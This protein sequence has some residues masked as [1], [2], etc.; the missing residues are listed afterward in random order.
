MNETC[1]S[2]SS[3]EEITIQRVRQIETSLIQKEKQDDE[4]SSINDSGYGPSGQFL[5]TTDASTIEA[6]T[7]SYPL[8]KTGSLPLQSHSH[9]SRFSKPLDKTTK[10]RFEEVIPIIEQLLDPIISSLPKPRYLAI[11]SMFL[12]KD[13]TDIDAY[14]IILCS[15]SHVKRIEHAVNT[16]LV[17]DL[18]QSPGVCPLKVL[19]IDRPPQPKAA[20]SCIEVC[21]KRSTTL[22]GT[23]ILLANKSNGARCGATRKAT[24]G[25]IIK[26]T[27]ADGTCNLYG[28][29]AGHV[30]D[31][32]QSTSAVT[33]KSDGTEHA[34][35]TILPGAWDFVDSESFGEILDR[36]EF[37]A[38]ASQNL[39]PSHDWVL[40]RVKSGQPNKLCTLKS[41]GYF[42]MRELKEAARPMFNDD[43]SDPVIMIGGSAGPKPGELSS[44]MSRVLIGL[45]DKFVDAYMLT[46]NEH[47]GELRVIFFLTG[48]P[49]TDWI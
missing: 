39:L 31:N 46:L 4:N 13:E 2:Q 30:L 7:R 25:G 10:E 44:F 8:V 24:V 16:P 14:M 27:L 37:T 26:V 20:Q 11:R 3:L 17:R 45:S 43:L 34:S 1:T 12:G 23:P 19:V 32:L 38:I 42:D 49:F 36:K 35:H 5:A 9:L 18:C 33:D 48:R 40:F 21:R 29:T 47:D 28:M 15:K 41:P 6:E 22:C